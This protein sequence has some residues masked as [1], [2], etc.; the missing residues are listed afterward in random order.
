M[1]A[2]DELFSRL[3]LNGQ[4]AFMPFITAGDPDLEFT[5]ECLRQLDTAGCHLI[6]LGIPYSDPIADGPRF[7]LRIHGRS[8]EAFDSPRFSRRSVDCGAIFRS[9]RH[10]GQLRHRSSGRI[11]GVRPTAKAAGMAG[12]I[13]PDLPVDEAAAFSAICREHDFDLIQLVTPTTAPTAPCGSPRRRPDS[14]TT[15][16]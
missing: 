5:A 12:A 9:G 8:I 13:V 4:K 6:E 15:F 7:K 2:I 11:G 14:C 1:S 10:H 16:P 3:K